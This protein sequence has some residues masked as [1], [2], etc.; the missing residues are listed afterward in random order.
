MKLDNIV[1]KDG[2]L[3][4]DI[5]NVHLPYVNGLRRAIL[6]N[7]Q[8]VGINGFPNED[9]DINII[10][11]DTSLNNEIIKHR[12]ISIPVHVLSPPNPIWK[13][14]KIILNKK[15][16]TDTIIAVT[17][18]DISIVDKETGT[19]LSETMI[20][21]I[22]PRDT[23]TNDFILICYLKPNSDKMKKPNE[24]HLEA[25]FSVVSPVISSVY[26]CVSKVT[27]SN[28]ID[29]EKQELGWDQFQATIDES[30]DIEREKTNWK[31]LQGQHYYRE[32]FYEFSIKSIGFIKNKDILQL[33]CA[34]IIK[35][36][37]NIKMLE[38]VSIEKS[39]RSNIPNT[40]DIIL[41]D[42]TYTIGNILKKTIYD[43]YY[44]SD[45][46]YVGFVLEHPHDTFSILRLSFQTPTDDDIIKSLLG[47][48][49][50]ASAEYVTK[51]NE[52]FATLP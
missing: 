52:M 17:S 2:K 13:N 14:L 31:L 40:Y 47:E 44:P 11:N 33:G 7:I 48:M 10:A 30:C 43:S 45:I 28:K 1:E 20:R 25:T 4:V 3:K 21:N 29:V 39:K 22:F 36:L 51:L 46:S 38:N 12:I 41:K 42:Q 18:G 9:C 34:Y 15:N 16:E 35:S 23:I 37:E 19:K 6:S 49:C 26:N 50:D 27:F 32:N 8:I 24:I 5:E